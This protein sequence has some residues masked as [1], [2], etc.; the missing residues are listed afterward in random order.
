MQ[1][2]LYLCTEFA[3]RGFFMTALQLNTNIYRSLGIISEDEGLLREASNYLT[4]L[5]EQFALRSKTDVLHSHD[6]ITPELR[7]II[8]AAR[9]ESKR[10]ETTVCRT[11]EELQ[12]HLDSL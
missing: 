5:A 7:A 2:L 10:G 9:E 8:E 6:V 12:Q 4:S 1:F 11:R 3:K